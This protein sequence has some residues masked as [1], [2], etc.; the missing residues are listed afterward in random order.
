[1]ENYVGCIFLHVKKAFNSLDRNISLEKLKSYGISGNEWEWLTSYLSF[2]QQYAYYQS[3]SSAYIG[4]NYGVP[5][6]GVISSWHY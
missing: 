4:F 1:M 2:R 6:G 5:Q 3:L